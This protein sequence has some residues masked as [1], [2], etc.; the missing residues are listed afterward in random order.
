MGKVVSLQTRKADNNKRV[1]KK[2][3]TVEE[4]LS[5]LE[6]DMLR[7]VDMSIELQEQVD[8]NSRIIRKLI[9]LLAQQSKVSS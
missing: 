9:R 3:L 7:V 2:Y 1:R 5:E 6:V 4:R 8:T